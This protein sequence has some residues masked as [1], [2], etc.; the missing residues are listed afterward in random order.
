M[1]STLSGLPKVFSAQ[2]QQEPT[3]K[4]PGQYRKVLFP[5]FWV[6][7]IAAIIISI[8]R[9]SFFK[10]RAVEITPDDP[11]IKN[12]LQ[13]VI[14][15]PI[16]SSTVDREIDKV[17]LEDPSIADLSCRK[18]LPD[19]LIC[20]GKK[21]TPV[22]N[23]QKNGHLFLVD[24]DGYAYTTT[25]TKVADKLLVEDRVNTDLKLGDSVISADMLEFY[26]NL[27]DSLKENKIGFDRLVING[28]VN[29]INCL[30]TS[31]VA[32]DGSLKTKNLT[33]ML[34]VNENIS[35][36]LLTLKETLRTKGDKITERIDLR[37]PSM[38]YIK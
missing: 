37:V 26:L 33:L 1:V 35:D 22:V 25:E 15:L 17:R 8:P 13:T 2:H 3:K 11:V 4:S 28:S 7:I 12:Q 16:F 5:I 34:T 32:D 29:Q 14:G 18:G 30:M 38:V 24:S 10:I 23:W 9:L 21:R 20:Q 31:Y 19:T 6:V 36:S 27:A